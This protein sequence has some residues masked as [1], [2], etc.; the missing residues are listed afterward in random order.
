MEKNELLGSLKVDM[1]KDKSEISV[2]GKLPTN[3]VADLIVWCMENLYFVIAMNDEK[4]SSKTLAQSVAWMEE[5]PLIALAKLEQ[6]GKLDEEKLAII[7][8]AVEVI[9]SAYGSK[10]TVESDSRQG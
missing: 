10:E 1:Y 4:Y 7:K 9:R 6:E 8:D 3:M 2:D 5:F